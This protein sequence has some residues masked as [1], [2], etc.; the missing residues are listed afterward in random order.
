MPRGYQ[1]NWNEVIVECFFN[2]T[3]NQDNGCLESNFSKNTNGYARIVHNRRP[4]LCHRIVAAIAYGL[5]YND[6]SWKALHKCNNPACVLAEHL[7]PG[8]DRDNMRDAIESGNR[9][10]RMLSD[11][12]IISIYEKKGLKSTYELA[13]EYGVAHTVIANIFNRKNYRYLTDTIEQDNRLPGF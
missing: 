12:E 3:P 13:A 7:Y 2:A 4:F 11:E 8:D 10:G 5:D 1:R 9:E 6:L